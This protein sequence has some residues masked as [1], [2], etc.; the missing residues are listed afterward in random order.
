MFHPMD[1]RPGRGVCAIVYN[2]LQE[3][4]HS[5]D[6]SGSNKKQDACILL[7][8][9]RRTNTMGGGS[10]HF[11]VVCVVHAEHTLTGLLPQEPHP[12]FSE[13]QSALLAVP[14]TQPALSQWPA[15]SSSAQAAAG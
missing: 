10:F 3:S 5:L 15:S 13:P 7:L 12:L 4:S 8:H 2:G 11:T 9:I 14:G 1:G 6:M